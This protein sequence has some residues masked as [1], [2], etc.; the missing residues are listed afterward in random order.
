MRV[1]YSILCKMVI[2][3]FLRIK[4]TCGK[5]LLGPDTPFCS[6]GICSAMTHFRKQQQLR[7]TFIFR[8]LGREEVHA[9]WVKLTQGRED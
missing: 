2:F 8:C 6:L 9:N 5:H 3:F 1:V 4:N 7:Q